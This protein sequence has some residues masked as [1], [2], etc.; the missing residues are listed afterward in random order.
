EVGRAGEGAHGDGGG[1]LGLLQEGAYDLPA[2][3]V[4][5]GVQDPVPGV[6]ALAREVELPLLAVEAGAPGRQLADAL[7]ALLD[8]HARGG[9][10]HDARPRAEGVLEME[11][12][13]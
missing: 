11:V 2:R 8:Q 4:T 5:Q 6:G 1:A 10:R 13:V 7:R 12:G 3:S 9:R